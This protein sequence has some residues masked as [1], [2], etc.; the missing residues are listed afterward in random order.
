[1]SVR[2]RTGASE[3]AHS[4]GVKGPTRSRWLV[5]VLG[6]RAF[7]LQIKYLGRLLKPV[8]WQGMCAEENATEIVG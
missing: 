2:T 6:Y 3:K 7:L 4:L 8:I 5:I 1:M